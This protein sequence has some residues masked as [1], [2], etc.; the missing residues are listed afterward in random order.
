MFQIFYFSSLS[1]LLTPM[2][3]KPN[4]DFV[5]KTQRLKDIWPHKIHWWTKTFY[6]YL[7]VSFLGRLAHNWRNRQLL[8]KNPKKFWMFLTLFL[9]CITFDLVFD[10]KDFSTKLL[11]FSHEIKARG[12]TNV[13]LREEFILAAGVSQTMQA[14]TPRQSIS[15]ASQMKVSVAF[16]VPKWQRDT[17]FVENPCF[18]KF[19]G[20]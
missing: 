8:D 18:V 6:F 1:F 5:S 10:E 12:K 9:T 20:K 4:K 17:S 16:S 7:I 15:S 19:C 11:N 13:E 2:I 3:H 14:F